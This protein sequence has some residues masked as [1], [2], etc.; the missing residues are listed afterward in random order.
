MI[1]ILKSS[2]FVALTGCLLYLA[3]TLALLNPAEFAG[4]RPV[5]PE[6]RS[7]DDDP[8]WKFK[9]PEFDQWVAQMKQEKD[10][11]AAREQQLND[12]QTRLDAERQEISTVTQTVAQLQAQFDQNVIRFRA[13][14][15]ENVKRQAKLIAAMSPEGAATLFGNMSDD[16]VVRILFTMKI[17]E[18]SLVLDAM[19][20]MGKTE[21]KH[22]A[23]LTERMHQVLPPDTNSISSTAP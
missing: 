8:S 22:A 4:A 21:S 5:V 17:D 7:A 13:G 3:T 18:A 6:Q 23:M 1:R 19:N 14:E 15:A 11:M 16:D 2:W 20:K 12:W 9:N 10:A